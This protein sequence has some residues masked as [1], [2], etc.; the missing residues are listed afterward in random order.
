MNQKDFVARRRSEWAWLEETL[1]LGRRRFSRRADAFPTAYRRAVRD[2][3][4]ART[5]NFDPFLVDRLD[6]MVSRGHGRLYEDRRVRWPGLLDFLAVDFPAAVRRERTLVISFAVAFLL[7]G[8]LAGFYVGRSPGAFALWFSQATADNLSEMYDPASTHF[9]TPRDVS[10]DADMFGY[11]I[12]NNISIAFQAFSTG[13]LLGVGS[14]LYLMYNGAFLGAATVYLMEAGYA[15]T[16][17]SFIAGHVAVELTAIILAGAAG[18]RLGMVIVRPPTRL[19]R[20]EGFRVVGRRV[21]PL[22]YGSVFFLV[23]AAAIEA[24]WS[25]RPFAPGT[26]YAFGAAVF[27]AMMLYFLLFGR[28]RRVR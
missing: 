3:N 20:K 18:W 8:L 24:F 22:V 13:F 9:P 12:Y 11:Y 16:F 2:L 27:A 10:G 14:V 4:I 17:F 6:R 28:D 5:E 23:L 1:D 26:K 19:S 7:V 21:L 15:E 25:S